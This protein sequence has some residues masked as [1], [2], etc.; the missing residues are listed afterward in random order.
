MDQ[1]VLLAVAIGLVVIF[2]LFVV[3]VVAKFYQKVEQ[4]RAMIVNTMRAEPEVTFTG[5]LVIPVLHKRETMDI[6]LKTIEIER[7]GKE[8]LICKDNIRADIKVKFFVR[9]NKTAADVLKVAQNIGCA[10]ASNQD[11]LENLFS[12]KFSE[13]LKTV[14][15][16]LDFVE[17]YQ[18]RDRFRDDII[19]QIGDDLSGYV[20]EDA[21]IDFLEQTPMEKLDPKNILAAQGIR[22]ITELT[23]EDRA[24]IDGKHLAEQLQNAY[25]KQTRGGSTCFHAASRTK[26]GCNTHS[27][28]STTTAAPATSASPPAPTS[29]RAA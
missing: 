20:L 15:K 10:R 13:A 27:H 26:R 7:A 21:A 23:D 5:R 4:G 28:T 11:T 12:A 24:G 14:G 16:A 1:L 8:G 25:M 18:A 19:A 6:S 17:L 2:A 22:K 29:S 3:A 9:V